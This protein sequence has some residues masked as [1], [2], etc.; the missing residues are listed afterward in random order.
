MEGHVQEPRLLQD[1]QQQQSRVNKLLFAEDDVR[2]DDEAAEAAVQGTLVQVAVIEHKAPVA[3]LTT[4]PVASARSR[5]KL[6]STTRATRATRA[7]ERGEGLAVPYYVMQQ[8]RA[9]LMQTHSRPRQTSVGA[10]NAIL[11][12]LG[13]KRY[14]VLAPLICERL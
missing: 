13:W 5:R 3:A 1:T 9:V 14:K 6:R 10:I 2:D 7:R 4:T 12:R 8:V 11:S